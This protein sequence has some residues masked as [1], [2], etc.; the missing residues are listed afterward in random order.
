M[1][2]IY[3]TA[4]LFH[5]NVNIAG[6]ACL[7]DKTNYSVFAKLGETYYNKKAKGKKALF[8]KET[9]GG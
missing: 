9:Q 5:H 4:I 8:V 3:F 6:G 1:Y 7:L 2:K